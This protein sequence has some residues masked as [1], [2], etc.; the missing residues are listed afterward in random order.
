MAAYTFAVR[1]SGIFPFDMLRY[2]RCWPNTS[3]DATTMAD[4][5]MREIT[6]RSESAIQLELHTR[7]QFQ[8]LN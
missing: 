7:S 6:L 1:G 8:R 5:G 4:K 3:D 2:D